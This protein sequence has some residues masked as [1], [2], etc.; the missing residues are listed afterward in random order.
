M[1][2]LR[3]GVRSETSKNCLLGSA[4]ILERDYEELDKHHVSVY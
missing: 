1:W 3:Q 4:R 2:L